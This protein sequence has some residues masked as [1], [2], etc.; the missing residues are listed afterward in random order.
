[1]KHQILKGVFL[2]F[3]WPTVAEAQEAMDVAPRFHAQWKI[4]EKIRQKLLEKYGLSRVSFDPKGRATPHGLS[5]EI[6]KRWQRLYELC[7]RDGCYYCDAD[8]GSCEA[9]TCGPQNAFCRPYMETEGNP[10]CGAE[11]ADYALACLLQI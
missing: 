1:M 3:L 7:L 9:G 6:L 5:P 2:L 8:E 4:E 10:Q 11:C